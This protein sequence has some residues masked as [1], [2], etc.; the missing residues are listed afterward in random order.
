MEV[1]VTITIVIFLGFVVIVTVATEKVNKRRT[2]C[3]NLI[4]IGSVME[5]WPDA[6]DHVTLT[7]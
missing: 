2:I 5:N 3:E 6:I 7:T 4:G 1:T